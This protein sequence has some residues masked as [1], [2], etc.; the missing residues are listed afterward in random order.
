M[1]GANDAQLAMRISGE[2][3]NLQEKLIE[4]QGQS[5]S[6]LEAQADMQSAIDEAVREKV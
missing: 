6:L 5:L 4:V 1:R 2:I 3:A